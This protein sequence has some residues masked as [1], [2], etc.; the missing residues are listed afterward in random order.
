MLLNTDGNNNKFSVK[1]ENLGNIK[2]TGVK[3]YESETVIPDEMGIQPFTVEKNNK[4]GKGIYEIDLKGVVAE[5][6]G[7]DIEITLY[8]T[9]E[10]DNNYVSVIEGKGKL[11]GSGTLHYTKGDSL[12]I[13]GTP[14]V[15]YGP[16]RLQNKD[17]I[18]LE[19]V[20]F[21]N[22]TLEKTTYYLVYN[23]KDSGKSQDDQQ[24]KLKWGNKC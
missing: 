19:E 21:D 18:I 24:K 5:T 6:F 16:K 9:T 8:K 4:T 7:S 22:E 17:Q 3:A 20:E 14:K 1:T 11:T 15:V 2:W 12:N 13:T 23:S 10:P